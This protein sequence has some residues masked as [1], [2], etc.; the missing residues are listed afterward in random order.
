MVDYK[1][2]DITEKIIGCSLKV[3]NT[4]GNGFPEIIYHRALAIEMAKQGI[5]YSS[6]EKM[7][8]FYEGQRVG[9]RRVDFL[10]ENQ[11][12]VELKAV[13]EL[14]DGHTAQILNYLKAFGLEVGLLLNFG[15]RKL[16]IK[17]YV[18]S[19]P[20]RTTETID[21]ADDAD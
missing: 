7:Q 11:V 18:N 10:V 3:H 1:H 17:R 13:S 21:N 14:Q 20:Q 8:V 4:I 5:C 15:A 6:E 19:K 16:E 2:S 12:M 9:V